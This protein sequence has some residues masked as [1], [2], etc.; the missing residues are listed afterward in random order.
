MCH[1][2]CKY[3]LAIGTLGRMQE[4]DALFSE[5][6]L[7]AGNGPSVKQYCLQSRAVVANENF[8]VANALKYIQEANRLQHSSPV[9]SQWQSAQLESELAY[10]YALN[11]E[12]DLAQQHY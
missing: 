12:S 7:S 5:V 10:S 6:L 11:G 8:E 9:R 2:R 3:A 4:A 1:L